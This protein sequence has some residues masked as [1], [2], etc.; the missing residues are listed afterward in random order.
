MPSSRPVP[1]TLVDAN[2]LW[3]DS[4]VRA[5]VQR[6]VEAPVLLR[7]GGP[8]TGGRVLELGTG[9]RGTGLRLALEVFGA[10][11]ADGVERFPASV[12]ACRAALRDLGD[13]VDVQEGDATALAAASASYDAVFA[14]HV[15]HHS[16]AWRAAVREAARVLRPGGR[17]YSCEMTARIVDSRPLRAVSHHPADGDR[18]TPDGLA[19]AC[20]AA[21]LTVT[22]QETRL[23]GCWTALVATRP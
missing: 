17:F 15:L 10:G 8:V 1:P 18:P 5:L 21:G 4:R 9:R 12:A 3:V 16:P 23:A 6:R 14:H 2:R 7:L 11:R 22:D 19:E 20:R 13:R